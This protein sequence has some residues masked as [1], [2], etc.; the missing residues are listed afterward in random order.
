[1]VIKKIPSQIIQ[2]IGSGV[3]GAGAVY[4]VY[5]IVDGLEVQRME[6]T[7]VSTVSEYTRPRPFGWHLNPNGMYPA[8]YGIPGNDCPCAY[9]P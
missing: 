7:S 2:K 6:L 1:M 3:S 4:S 5:S 8:P 9:A